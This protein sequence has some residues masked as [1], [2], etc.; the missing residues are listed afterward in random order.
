MRLFS[1]DIRNDG[2]PS[3]A[4]TTAAVV[5]IRGS[6][7]WVANAGDSKVILCRNSKVSRQL[8][9]SK[10]II[11]SKAVELTTDHRLSNEFEK[12]GVESRGGSIIPGQQGVLRV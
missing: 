11:S 4:G 12:A 2:F 1:S 7:C 6:R 5:L 10:R 9:F 3:T 8:L